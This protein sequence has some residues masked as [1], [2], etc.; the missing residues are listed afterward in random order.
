[1]I[2]FTPALAL[3]P[4]QDVQPFL[5]HGHSRDAAVEVFGTGVPYKDIA[6]RRG[7]GRQ[8]PHFSR[9]GQGMQEDQTVR[10]G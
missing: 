7:T 2:R 4:L 8:G 6:Y 9:R 1:M 3:A 5:V 10:D